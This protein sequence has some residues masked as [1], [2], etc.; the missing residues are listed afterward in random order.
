M[1]RLYF[2]DIPPKRKTPLGAHSLWCPHTLGGWAWSHDQLWPLGCWQMW[3][4]RG[5]YAAASEAWL[6]EG[7]FLELVSRGTRHPRSSMERP[8][9]TAPAQ[10][11]A[12]LRMTP[13]VQETPELSRGLSGFRWQPPPLSPGWVHLESRATPTHHRTERDNWVLLL[14]LLSFG[15]VC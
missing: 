11:P 3:C 10:L 14:K 7:S 2:G 13:A 4:G 9:P 1:V 5:L 8:L 12:S 15:V 6:L